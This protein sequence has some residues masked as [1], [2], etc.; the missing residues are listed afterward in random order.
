MHELLRMLA[1]YCADLADVDSADLEIVRRALG[2]AFDVV[3]FTEEARWHRAQERVVNA[4]S[5][6]SR[7]DVALSDLW[8]RLDEAAEAFDPRTAE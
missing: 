4:V 3:S 5:Y 7:A 6:E 8:K 1:D 2:D